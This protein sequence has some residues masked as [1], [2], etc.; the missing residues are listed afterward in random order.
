MYTAYD[1][2]GTGE[3]RGGV[4]KGKYRGKSDEQWRL[5]LIRGQRIVRRRG[6]AVGGEKQEVRGDGGGHDLG[7]RAGSSEE[8][9]HPCPRAEAVAEDLMALTASFFFE[10]AGLQRCRLCFQQ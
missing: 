7:P 4:S 8:E 2:V 5:L 9:E 6:G 1:R 3:E 10:N